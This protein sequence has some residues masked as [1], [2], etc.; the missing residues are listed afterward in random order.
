M[1]NW[2][3]RF[4]RLEMRILYAKILIKHSWKI[5]EDLCFMRNFIQIIMDIVMLDYKPN[6]QM[7]LCYT[8]L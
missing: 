2:L 6:I 3:I 7:E 8:S 1:K 4:I 5:N